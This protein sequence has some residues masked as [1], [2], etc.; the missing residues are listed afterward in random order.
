MLFDYKGSGYERLKLFH[1]SMSSL[2]LYIFPAV[3]WY[4]NW[5]F[6]NS[7]LVFLITLI[8]TACFDHTSFQHFKV[9][10]FKYIKAIT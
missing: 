10:H 7:R 6:T 3:N 1:Q 8:H 9:I 5:C 2:L 4:V